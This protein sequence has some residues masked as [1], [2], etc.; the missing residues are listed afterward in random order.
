MKGLHVIAIDTNVLVRVLVDDVGQIEQTQLARQLVSQHQHVYLTQIVQIECVWVLSK[1][2]KVDK[3]ML[4]SILQHLDD[5]PAYILQ[6]AECF[7]KALALFRMGNADFSDYIIV[8]ECLA[9]KTVLYTFDKR[10]SRHFT[11]QLLS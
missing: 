6:Q 10:L 9:F 11:T 7:K 8:S 5:N 4:V 3:P 1:V 2:Y